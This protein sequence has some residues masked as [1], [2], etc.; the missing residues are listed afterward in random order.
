[1]MMSSS[2]KRRRGEER[3]GNVQTWKRNGVGCK[4]SNRGKLNDVD[5]A[6]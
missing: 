5:I 3:R 4:G 6:G 2:E 1:M